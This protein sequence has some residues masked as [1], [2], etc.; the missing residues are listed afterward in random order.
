MRVEIRADSVCLEG[1]VNAVGRDSR[2]ISSERGKFI[3][4]IEPKTFAKALRKNPNVELRFNHRRVLGSTKTGELE[5][6]EDAIGLHA[7]CTVTDTEVIEKAKRNELR[8]WSFGFYNN[9]DF[10]E[11][12]GNGM[13]RRH[14]QDIDLTEVSILD[15][16]PAY[17]AMSIEQRDGEENAFERR[18]MDDEADTVDLSTKEPPNEEAEERDLLSLEKRTYEFLKMKGGLYNEEQ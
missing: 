1:Y 18:S 16:T 11:D 7:K 12:A 3:E 10:W 6:C 9:K 8:G 17:I 4:Q 15:K 13:Q 5:L 2:P 14:L